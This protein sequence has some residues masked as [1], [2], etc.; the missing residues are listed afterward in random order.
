[1]EA[2]ET[3]DALH[4]LLDPENILDIPATNP[5]STIPNTG[6]LGNP[7]QGLTITPTQPTTSQRPISIPVPEFDPDSLLDLSIASPSQPQ[8]GTTVPTTTCSSLKARIEE[9]MKSYKKALG[10]LTS[11]GHHRANMAQAINTNNPP[12]GLSPKIRAFSTQ[13]HYNEKA[14]IHTTLES[15][16]QKTKWLLMS[17]QYLDLMNLATPSTHIISC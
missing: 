14:N 8:P 1:M 9:Q 3:R 2:Q 15:P 6:N 11:A 12:D 10:S 16:L 7:N 13:H 5:I 17:C 4:I